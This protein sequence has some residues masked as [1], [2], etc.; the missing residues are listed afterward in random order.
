MTE[1]PP[2]PPPVSV[3][4]QPDHQP[5]QPKQQQ[6]AHQYIHP[7]QPDEIAVKV[8]ADAPKVKAPK[9]VKEGEKRSDERSRQNAQLPPSRMPLPSR[10]KQPTNDASDDANNHQP[11][12]PHLKSLHRHQFPH[13]LSLHFCSPI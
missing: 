12:Q 4:D 11:S 5:D 6:I 10:P 8:N 1:L 9:P 3:G 7:M 13:Q 2:Q